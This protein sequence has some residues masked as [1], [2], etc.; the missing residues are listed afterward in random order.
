MS[1]AGASAASSDST[2]FGRANATPGDERAESLPFRR[3]T[4]GREGAERAAVEAAL[5]RDDPRPAGRLA[6]DLERSLVRLGAGVAEE[7]PATR[8]ALREQ[9]GEPQHRLRPV[10]I[11]RVPEAVELLVGGRERRRREVPEADDGDPGHEVEV[12]AAGVVPDPAAVAAHDRDI[13][14]RVGRQ[15]RVAQRR[16]RCDAVTGRHATTSVAP[17]SAR[18][19]PR[20]AR[21][22]ASSLG[23]CRPRRC[24]RRASGR[25]RRRRCARSRLPPSA[26]RGHR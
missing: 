10:E 1:P 19:P 2:S 26:P 14:P 9:G 15:H 25:R 12:L 23:R 21:T 22:A 17:I 16:R 3:L 8:E 24:R 13:G 4:G 18:T 5:E 7:R 20:A 11:R 6:G